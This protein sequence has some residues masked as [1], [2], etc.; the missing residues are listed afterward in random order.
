[1]GPAVD[2]AQFGN[3]TGGGDYY[4]VRKLGLGSVAGVEPGGFER[5]I[6]VCG[7]AAGGFYQPAEIYGSIRKLAG[8][9]AGCGRDC[10]GYLRAQY[11]A[12]CTDVGLGSFGGD[13]KFVD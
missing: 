10:Y 13:G 3:Y 8:A 11:L 1:M 4:A 6:V 5:A 12:D 7:L 9:E 2:Y